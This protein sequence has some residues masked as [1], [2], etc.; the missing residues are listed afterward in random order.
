MSLY[1]NV[2]IGNPQWTGSLSDAMHAILAPAVRSGVVA[3]ALVWAVGAAVLPWLGRR[4]PLGG[5]GGPRPRSRPP[6]GRG[7]RCGG[8]GPGCAGTDGPA[9]VAEGCLDQVA[10]GP[11]S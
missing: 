4:G 9:P 7:S 5:G 8:S 11:D 3:P 10:S 2:P 6:A 1:L